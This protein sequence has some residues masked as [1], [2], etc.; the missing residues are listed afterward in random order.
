VSIAFVDTAGVAAGIILDPVRGELFTAIRRQGARL[1]GHP[2]HVSSASAVSESLLVTGFPYD[3]EKM[4]AA[5]IAR[6]TNCLRSARGVRR[7]GAAALDLCYVACGRFDAFW[8]QHL[9]PWDT[10]AGS[11]IAQEAGARVTDFDG[12]PFE[13]DDPEVLASNGRIHDAML[14]LLKFETHDET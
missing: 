7:L 10:A 12:K 6:F 2:I 1:N 3:Y 9:K 8:E 11:L 14:R 5:V 13:P 4:F